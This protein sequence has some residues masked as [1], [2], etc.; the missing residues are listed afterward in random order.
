MRIPEQ[1]LLDHL[2]GLIG[3]KDV[4]RHYL[5]ANQALLKLKGL[6]NSAEIADKTDED[7]SPWSIEDNHIFKQQDLR[8][9]SGEKISAIHL[10]SKSNEVF[11]LEKSP[12]TDQNNKVTGLIYHCRSCHKDNV[13]KR[14][15]K[16]DEQLN[17]NTNHYNL[18]ENSNK[19]GLTNRERECVFL[20]IRGQSAKE[21]GTLLSLS[22]RTIESYIENIKNKMNCKNKAEILVKAVLNGYHN[23]IPASLNQAAIIASL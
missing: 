19:F 13:F 4:N 14:L 3:W 18:N 20:L 6:R 21:I 22:K 17:L 23:H 9:L 2:S 7:L 1:S 8:V 16:L 15:K 11:Q 10:D 12:I 5:G